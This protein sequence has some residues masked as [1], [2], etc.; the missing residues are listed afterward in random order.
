[1]AT[2]SD[3]NL[4]RI[5]L[6]DSVANYKQ[7]VANFASGTV[8]Q[9]DLDD[10]K[11]LAIL[12]GDEYAVLTVQ[13]KKDDP[14]VTNDDQLFSN[15]GKQNALVRDDIA[16]ILRTGKLFSSAMKLLV[17]T[18]GTTVDA[19]NVI[20]AF[21]EGSSVDVDWGDASSVQ[22]YTGAASHNYA[23]PGQY[24]VEVTGQVNGFTSPL[25]E[26]RQQI[27]DVMQWGEVQFT[28]AER[29]FIARTGFVISA[30]DGPTFL[31]GAS[32][33]RMFT[34]TFDFNSP[35][36]H[37]DVSNV[38]N[39][40][41]LF[42]GATVFNQDLSDWDVSGVVN[43]ERMFSA[44]RAFNQPLNDWNVS[45][46]T[47]LGEMFRQTSGFNQPL[48][49]WDVSSATLMGYMF[50]EAAVFNQDLSGWVV[51]QVTW[52]TSFAVSSALVAGNLPNFQ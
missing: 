38:V 9:Q 29:M 30:S 44:A 32:I 48:N 41:H 18:E 15:P 47:N 3:L 33:S 36:G 12:T 21:A 16:T 10:A 25:V 39:A 11:E 23:A 34:S 27:K 31:P 45:N 43:M 4:K 52:S 49:L 2:L 26:S 5:E 51:G 42:Y 8:T 20:L 28:S 24:T 14:N 50:T 6:N 19:T 22:S 46:V 17:D 37:W 13:V 7:A 40:S 1:M 35:I